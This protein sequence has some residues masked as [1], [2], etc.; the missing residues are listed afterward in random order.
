MSLSAVV[1]AVFNVLQGFLVTISCVKW[2]YY[3]SEF[4]FAHTNTQRYTNNTQFTQV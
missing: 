2:F 3:D 4:E 1:P